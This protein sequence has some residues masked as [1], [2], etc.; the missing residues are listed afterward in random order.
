MVID[1]EE[2][3]KFIS[4]EQKKLITEYDTKLSSYFKLEDNT[5]EITGFFYIELILDRLGEIER[6]INFINSKASVDITPI[7]EFINSEKCKL[8]S[9]LKFKCSAAE[10]ENIVTFMQ[11]IS[12]F[13]LLDT[14]LDDA[15]AM[16]K[17]LYKKD[18]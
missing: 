11:K 18:S 7:K 8:T 14:K 9:Q 3:K 17:K 13:S 4:E 12:R 5:E 6:A 1:T 16:T 10:K 15:E 2:V